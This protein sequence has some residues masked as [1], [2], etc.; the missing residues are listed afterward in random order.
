MLRRTTIVIGFAAVA[1][2][3]VLAAMMGAGNLAA[4]QER[5]ISERLSLARE[6]NAH[7]DNELIAGQT[8]LS[9][10]AGSSA[11]AERDFA[12]ARARV[13]AVA[14]AHR[15]WR[16]VILTDLRSGQEVWTLTEAEAPTSPRAQRSSVTA[17]L[18]GDRALTIGD[19]TGSEPG[20]PCVSIHQPIQ[21]DDQARYL[22][23]V[24]L[25][26][27]DMQ[28][29]LMADVSPPDI[30]AVVDRQGNFIAR[31]LDYREK[32]GQPATQ[33]VRSAIA[34][35]PSGVYE[36]VTYEG[37][38]NRTAY[39]T[40]PLSGFS[41]H[42]AIPRVGLSALAAGSAGLGFLA[43]VVALLTAAL[44]I[45]YAVREQARW[46]AV[47]RTRA[48]SLKFE[49]IGQLASGVA[50]D[51]NN[52]LTIILAS[53]R[54]LEREASPGQLEN[55]HHIRSAAERG[56]ALVKQLMS[57]TRD[58]PIALERV[59]LGETLASIEALLAQTLGATIDLTI[60]VAPGACV[61]TNRVQLESALVN[62]ASN[63]RD[64]MPDGG[65]FSIRGKVSTRANCFD[66][67]VTDTGSGM[68]EA[69]L[70]R[71]LD[72]FFTTKGANGS[73]IGLA[74]VHALVVQSSGSI[75]IESTPG[76]GTTIRL[77]LPSCP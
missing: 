67:I 7:I 44:G 43:L 30:G 14:S 71:A 19:I 42:I 20:C 55:I 31:T 58:K 9:V 33:Y 15:D 6:V 12:R 53:T 8:A 60:E 29:A 64:A 35:A 59:D 45:V 28:Q 52:F 72:P 3:I 11:F 46:R 21:V 16:N 41:T 69:V 47:E 22:L 65:G 38:R 77:T 51:F 2:L 74:Q 40:S 68:S 5:A 48:R 4:V 56:A 61:T 73:G 27:A 32:L 54:K 39:V 34:E 36:G 17:Y 25:D 24:E 26:V 50:H 76:Q 37:L 70:Q 10:L 63:A 49:A 13:Q 23:T 75:D 18:R 66:I 57:F 62:L 1:P